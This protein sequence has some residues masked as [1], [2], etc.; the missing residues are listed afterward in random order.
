[1]WFILE[2]YITQI[3]ISVT[4]RFE[5]IS[6]LIKET[7][8]IAITLNHTRARVK[9]SR[10]YTEE[11][12]VKCGVK[13]GDPL[14]ATLFSLLIDAKLKQM[15]LRGNIT[16]RLKQCTAYAN[17]IL[18]TTRTKQSLIDTLQKI[19][20]ISA[21]YGLIVNGQK[22]KYLRCARKYYNLEELQINSMYLEKNHRFES[23]TK[24]IEA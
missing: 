18:L 21:Q 5:C 17:D 7:R 9:I 3:L 2:F 19:K 23:T 8:L 6:R 12:I 11:F 22:T 10:D 15:E 1:V 4:S 13:Q 20:K 14:S 16:T 24:S